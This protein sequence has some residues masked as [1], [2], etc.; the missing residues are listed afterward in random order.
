MIELHRMSF[1]IALLTLLAA[2]PATASDRV[3]GT[4]VA[5]SGETYV[6]DLGGEPPVSPGT[7]LQAWRQL[8]SARGTGAYRD[9]AVWWDVGRL[10]VRSVSDG[11]AVAVWSGPA[12]EPMP[13]GLDESGVPGELVQV[14]DRVRATAA[15]GERPRDVRVTFALADLFGPADRELGSGGQALFDRWLRGL[16][17][18]EGPIEVEVHPRLA[19]LGEVG[20]DLSRDLSLDG[21]LP[22]GPAPGDG[23]V[24]VEG[25]YEGAP[26]PVPVPDAREV[27]VV[28]RGA[29]GPD[30][31][32]YLDPI[33]LARRRGEH[34]AAALSAHLRLPP[35]AVLVRVVPRPAVRED[36]ARTAPGYD[37]TGDQL[38]ILAT[39]I[40][41]AEPV[42][43]PVRRKVEPVEESEEEAED[44]DRR[45]RILEKPPE[46]IS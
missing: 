27:M 30:V 36:L 25:L 2:A 43:E 22:F 21:D 7:I 37:T 20:P 45:R 18:V 12:D 35:E 11:L 8:P 46:E 6:V 34:I 16:E 38:R 40:Q 14:G 44:K 10:T 15:V 39:A 32:R 5:I 19:E 33:S 26:A 23:V 24:P 3:A 31:W 13:F 29:S 1:A 28:E 9:S 42:D 4:V 41:W 17:S